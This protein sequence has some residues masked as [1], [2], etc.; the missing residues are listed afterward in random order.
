MTQLEK[1]GLAVSCFFAF[2]S[3]RVFG[4]WVFADIF[5]IIPVW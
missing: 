5:S 1:S 2:F 4:F 3:C